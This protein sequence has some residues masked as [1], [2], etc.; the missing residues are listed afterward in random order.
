[1]EIQTSNDSN[2]QNSSP[3]LDEKPTYELD[4]NALLKCKEIISTSN[5]PADVNSI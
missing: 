2:Y 3:L 5:Q 1:M 4:T